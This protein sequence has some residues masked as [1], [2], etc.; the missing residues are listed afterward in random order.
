MNKHF[1]R[2]RIERITPAT[3]LLIVGIVGSVIFNN[4]KDGNIN[5]N[6]FSI[7][8]ILLFIGASISVIHI[9]TH[10][11]RDLINYHKLGMGRAASI[12]FILRTIGYIIVIFVTLN[13][14]NIPIANILVG[15]AVIG[16]IL[17][18]AAQ[19]ALANFFASIVLIISK[20]FAVG[21]EVSFV[22]GTLGGV[23]KG[24]VVDIGLTHTVLKEAEDKTVLLPNVALLSNT[25]ITK[26]K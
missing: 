21:E 14:L 3:I 6:L 23:H 25:A 12:K 1:W 22:S 9:F 8:F 10:I 17:G 4:A 13:L 24:I 11:I 7:L 16:I 18:V 19:Q 15:G 5:T 26:I 20:P 2:H